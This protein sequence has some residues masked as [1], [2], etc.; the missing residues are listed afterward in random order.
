MGI[1]ETVEWLQREVRQG[2][3]HLAVNVTIRCV[4]FLWLCS[5]AGA[6]FE[7]PGL[8]GAHCHGQAAGARDATAHR[9]RR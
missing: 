6:A 2:K 7:W 4:Q 3:W 8:G 1:A 5:T 9:Q